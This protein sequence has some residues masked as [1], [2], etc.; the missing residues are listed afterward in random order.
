[1]KSSADAKY[2]RIHRFLAAQ[3]FYPILLSTV[4]ACGFY[5]FRVFYSYNLYYKNLIWNLFLAW[6]PYGC[7]IL[8]AYL[9]R[10]HPARSWILL[11][12][13][14]LWL[15]FFPNAPYMVT[16]FYH[17]QHRPPVPLW[18]D[19][20]LIAAFAWT[21]CFLAVASL[22]TM[23]S[24]VQEFFGRIAGWLFVVMTLAGSGVGVYLGR[25]RRF[26]SWD[27]LLHPRMVL[28]DLAISLTDPSQ[29]LRFIGFCFMFTA[30]L[31][32]FYWMFRSMRPER[33]KGE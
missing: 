31:F 18:Y 30:I 23:Q 24:L 4:L 5:L 17:L 25:F 12:P 16:D 14:A 7:S 6:L 2:I 11:F 28:G 8:A 1:M 26:N 20:G 21:G 10:L 27:L 9:Y 15:I 3:S 33:Q 29:S 32:V 13:G 19:I 22:R